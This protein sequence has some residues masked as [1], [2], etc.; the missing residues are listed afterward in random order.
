M[1]R[2]SSRSNF[3]ATRRIIDNDL[4]KIVDDSRKYKAF[5]E[6]AQLSDKEA[7]IVLS[8][9]LGPFCIDHAYPATDPIHGEKVISRKNPGPENAYIRLNRIVL[10]QFEVMLSYYKRVK[11]PR[12]WCGI[13][14]P[15]DAW[16]HWLETARM[17][18]ES[19][20]LHEL[21]HWGDGLDGVH[22]D[23]EALHTY[24]YGDHGHRFVEAA[25]GSR[26]PFKSVGHGRVQFAFKEIPG[27]YGWDAKTRLPF[28]P[29]L[30]RPPPI[31]NVKLGT[32]PLHYQGG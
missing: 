28:T 8:R 13:L 1:A 31:P 30:R 4:P 5:K 17:Y 25:Y 18:L 15:R 23:Y 32:F 9:G 29:D 11:N 7:G 2:L 19:T 20:I 14:S 10:T 12:K 16:A 26:I 3:P 6:Y 24:R 27:W 22:E 21:V